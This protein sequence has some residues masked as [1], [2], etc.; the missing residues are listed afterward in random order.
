MSRCDFAVG[1][2]AGWLLVQV[3]VGGI[4]NGVSGCGYGSVLVGIL[5]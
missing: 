5:G 4:V 2:A 3:S 1:I